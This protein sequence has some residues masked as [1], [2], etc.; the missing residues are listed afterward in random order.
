[1]IKSEQDCFDQELDEMREE[2]KRL[3]KIASF[4]KGTPEGRVRWQE[5]V[6][7]RSQYKNK[8]VTKKYEHNQFKL[9]QAKGDTKRTWK[10]MNEIRLNKD[11][12]EIV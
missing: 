5:Y 10:V 6:V 3:Y 1:M 9:N 4:A 2:K 11:H 12:S 7:H 8:I